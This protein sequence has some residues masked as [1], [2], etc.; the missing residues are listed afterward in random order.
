LNLDLFLK[1]D[2]TTKN[3]LRALNLDYDTETLKRELRPT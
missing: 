2:I 1:T 3:K